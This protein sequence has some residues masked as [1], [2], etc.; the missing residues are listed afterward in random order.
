MAWDALQHVATTLITPPPLEPF[1]V[2]EAKLHCRI[3]IDDEDVSVQNWIRAARTKVEKDTGRALLTQT[4]DLFLDRFYPPAYGLSD[5]GWPRYYP[6]TIQVPYPPLQS[7]ISVNQ[8]D[9]AGVET[10]W[11]A[12]NYVVDVASVP[13]RIALSDTGSWPTGTRSFQPGRV[14]FVAG[15]TS[16]E[17]IPDDLRQAMLLLIGHFSEQRGAVNFENPTTMVIPFGYDALISSYVMFPAA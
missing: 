8:T 2:E 7:V 14:R 15:W 6:R 5:F 3:V 16:P 17:L 10:V 12:S 9:P 13:G 11:N 1:S 4:W